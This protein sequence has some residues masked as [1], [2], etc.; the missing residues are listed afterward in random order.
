MLYKYTFFLLFVS[1][2]AVG[3]QCDVTDLIKL[4]KSVSYEDF[5]TYAHNKEFRF[6]KTFKPDLPGGYKIRDGYFFTKKINQTSETLMFVITANLNDKTSGSEELKVS[7]STYDLGSFNNLK[8]Q[9]KAAG[10]QRIRTT[11]SPDGSTIFASYYNNNSLV[12]IE[13]TISSDTRYNITSY[14]VSAIY[15]YR[16]K[17]NSFDK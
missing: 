7:Y 12:S 11:D 14:E 13:T 9:I 10:Y 3:Q 16:T 15:G 17:K 8:S 1:F 4:A 6:F 5:E 2:S